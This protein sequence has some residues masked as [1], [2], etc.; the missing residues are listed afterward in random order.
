[1]VLKTQFP[2]SAIVFHLTNNPRRDN[3]VTIRVDGRKQTLVLQSR[4]SG[5]LEFPVKTGFKIVSNYLHRVRI[6]VA[7]DSRPYFEEEKNAERR[8]LGVFFEIEF[9]PAGGTR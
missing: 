5:T 6:G 2:V 1:M 4:E 9:V 8:N 7:K 3:R